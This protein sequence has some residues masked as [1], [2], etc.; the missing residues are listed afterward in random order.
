MGNNTI[1]LIKVYLKDFKLSLDVNW[2]FLA[3]LT[4]VLIAVIIIRNR[5]MKSKGVQFE[6]EKVEVNIGNQKVTIKPNYEDMQIAYR[7]WTELSTRKIGLEIDFD[8]DVIDEVYESWYSFFQI[9]RGMIGD[10]PV[11]QIRK[12]D[13]TRQIVRMSLSILNDGL[14]PHLTKWQAN[15]RGWY[16]FK[17]KQSEQKN[18]YCSPQELQKEFSHY[19]DLVEDMREVNKRLVQYRN[20][21]KAVFMS[22]VSEGELQ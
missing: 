11:S 19:N 21:L 20:E 16:A 8:N 10:I 18:E 2:A 17:I 5:I 9:T 6:V 14:R 22:S 12:N 1:D 15:F 13:S 7:L 4:V 3:L